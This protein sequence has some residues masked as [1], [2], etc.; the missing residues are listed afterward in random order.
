MKKYATVELDPIDVSSCMLKIPLHT[1]LTSLAIYDAD[2]SY[3]QKDYLEF[4]LFQI[5]TKPKFSSDNF[6]NL[7][8][9]YGNI[10]SSLAA[11]SSDLLVDIIL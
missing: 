8:D 4:I 2:I 3:L 6:R 7:Q 9:V 10:L 11:K 1:P 5:R